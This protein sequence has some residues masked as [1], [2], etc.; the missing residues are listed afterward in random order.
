MNDLS[1]PQERRETCRAAVREFLAYRPAVAHHPNDI[2]RRLNEGHQNDFAPVE[3]TD[4]LVFLVDLN[5]AQERRTPLGATKYYQITS[6]GILAH[7]RG[8]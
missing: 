3:V 2:C 4:A 5:H 7:E 8:Q 1:I 6:A